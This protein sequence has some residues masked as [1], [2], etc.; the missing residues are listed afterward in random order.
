MPPRQK[1]KIGAP[2]L[3]PLQQ[4]AEET[5]HLQSPAPPPLTMPDLLTALKCVWSA[6]DSEGHKTLRLRGRD[7]RALAGSCVQWLSLP[8]INGSDAVLCAASKAFPYLQKLELRNASGDGSIDSQ[9]LAR[10]L[11]HANMTSLQKLA[12]VGNGVEPDAWS[13]SLTS[14]LLAATPNLIKISLSCVFVSD[15]F[16]SGIS[17][18][19]HLKKLKLKEVSIVDSQALKVGR[20][21]GLNISHF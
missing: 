12:V 8:V 9:Q 3:Q 10:A 5:A 14:C 16:F 19:E 4:V 17:R 1:R 15:V 7:I 6:L 11:F 21:R 18:L 13:L 20:W 2:A